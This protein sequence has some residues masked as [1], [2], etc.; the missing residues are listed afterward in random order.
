MLVVQE[1]SGP[2]AAHE[3]WKMPTGLLD[4]SEDVGDAAIRELKEET[5]LDGTVERILSIRQAHT[6]GRA[7]RIYSLFAN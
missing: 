4:P 1:K 5:G 2:A 6:Q 7:L 3:L